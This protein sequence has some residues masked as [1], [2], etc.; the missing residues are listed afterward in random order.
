LPQNDHF[1]K[2]FLP[3]LF[4]VLENEYIPYNSLHF[5][6]ADLQGSMAYMGGESKGV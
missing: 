2:Y 3:F 1:E 4:F 5:M 6:Y